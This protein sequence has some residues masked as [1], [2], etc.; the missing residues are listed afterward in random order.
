MNPEFLREGTA[1][2]DFLNPDRI[3]IGELDEKSGDKLEKIYSEF[4]APVV[5]TGLKEAELIKYGSNSLLATKISFINEIGNLCKQ[6]GIDVYDVA[7]GVGMD[8]RL[9]RSFLNSGIGFGGSC[10]PKDVRALIRFMEEEGEDPKILRNVVELNQGQ[11]VKLVEQLEQKLEDLDGKTVAV[12]GLS[13]KPG[14][15]DIRQS[16][17]IDIISELKEKDVNVKAYDPE[18][19]EN[20]EQRHPDTVYTESYQEALEG[21]DAALLVTDWPEFDEISRKDLKT[22][23]NPLILEGRRMDYDLPDDK[24]EGVT[25]P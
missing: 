14:T 18:A 22:M 7:D 1:L 16:P 8:S 21:S 3:V 13:F 25:W 19:M 17:A 11:K 23:E 5:R 24:T 4:E 6:L 9:E 10:F 12:L 20:M 15:D 2:K